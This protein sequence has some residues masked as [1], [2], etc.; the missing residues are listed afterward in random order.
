MLLKILASELEK[1]K[2]KAKIKAENAK[3]AI[4]ELKKGSNSSAEKWSQAYKI[5]KRC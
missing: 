1:L 3:K 5:A 4:E 2:K